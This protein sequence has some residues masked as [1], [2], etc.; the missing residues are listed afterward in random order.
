MAAP[1]K[2]KFIINPIAGARK[3]TSIPDLIHQKLE[4]P[5][6]IVEV[7]E[8]TCKGHAFELS[9]QAVADGFHCVVAVGGDG[10]INETASALMHT[11]AVLGII[12]CGSGNG[13]A[14]HLGIPMQVADALELIKNQHIIRID[15]GLINDKPFFCTAG[16]G[17]DAHIGKI[18]AR[19]KKRG[20]NAYIRTVLQEFFS[21]KTDE[22]ILETGGKQ[23]KREAFLITF[24]NA[25]QYGNNAYI[26]PQADIQDGLLDMCIIKPY[27]KYRTVNLCL[28]LFNKTI[29]KS[30]FVEISHIAEAR[31]DAGNPTCYHLDGEHFELNKH[32][33]VKVVPGC[34]DVLTG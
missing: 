5:F 34:L 8:T 6:F 14:R 21:Y 24:A 22:Y 20:F 10:T 26:S 9:K 29:H 27:P 1:K 13:L 15:A 16:I 18:F 4:S 32:I 33:E 23:E 12:P 28:R 25:N 2:V 11:R 7:A 30:S 19:T 3:N 31:V 17:F